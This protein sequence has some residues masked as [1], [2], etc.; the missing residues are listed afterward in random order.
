MSK[1]EITNVRLANAVR[2]T[3]AVEAFSTAVENGQA[4]LALDILEN[5]IPALVQRIETLETA[6]A[7][8]SQPKESLQIQA[9]TAP[10]AA[11]EN[12][13]VKDSSESASE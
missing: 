13:E 6:L 8:K 5:I 9:K 2:T 1:I 4:R 10:K 11:K 7:E 3:D 12:K